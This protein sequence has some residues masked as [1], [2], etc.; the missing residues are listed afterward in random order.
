ME[1]YYERRDRLFR[2]PY[3]LSDSWLSPG[4]LEREPP[5]RRLLLFTLAPAYPPPRT[6]GCVRHA[7]PL[8]H[9]EKD[10]DLIGRRRPPRAVTHEGGFCQRPSNS[11]IENMIGRC[12]S[13][14]LKC[15][16]CEPVD[17]SVSRESFGMESVCSTFD[18]HDV[19]L[20]TTNR[21]LYITHRENL[22]CPKAIRVTSRVIFACVENAVQQ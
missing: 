14:T 12:Y 18:A 4:Q 1:A 15:G 9:L 16:S 17:Y 21:N 3:S 5:D 11:K 7:C 10:R 22:R 2:A 20:C 6:T 19:V 13:F 8:N